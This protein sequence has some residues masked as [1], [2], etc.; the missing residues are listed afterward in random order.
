MN[1]IGWVYMYAYISPLTSNLG[2]E[3]AQRRWTE[4]DRSGKDAVLM[5]EIMKYNFDMLTLLF[6][7]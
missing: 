3:G 6:G 1:S 2:K 7:L 5:V 4:M